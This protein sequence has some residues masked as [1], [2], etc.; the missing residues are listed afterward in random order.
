[1]KRSLFFVLFSCV[2]IV[3]GCAKKSEVEDL[4]K[5]IDEIKS[6]QIA[7]IN[8]QIT[9]I[10]SSILLLENMDQT[11]KANIDDLSDDQVELE[12]SLSKRIDDLK[13]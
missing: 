10:M 12:R 1:M 13:I 11:L 4:Q 3:F 5:Q 9:N 6:T 8:S 7:T 2:C